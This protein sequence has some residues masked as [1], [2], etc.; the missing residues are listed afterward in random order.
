MIPSPV[1]PPTSPAVD[2]NPSPSTAD[3]APASA[4]A[5][6]PGADPLSLAGLAACVAEARAAALSPQSSPP[7]PTFFSSLR[8]RIEKASRELPE[9]YRAAVADPLRRALDG[10]GPGG[11]ARILAVDPGR[12]GP[13]RL[14]LDL[15]QAVLQRGEGYQARATAAFQEVVS[16]L[17]EGFLSAEDRRGV[18][19]PDHGVTPPLVR[20]G[21]AETGPYTW[22]ARVTATF[23]VGAAVVSLPA[24]NA[25]GG[26]LAWPALAHEAAGHDILEA[27]DGLREELARAVR[28]EVRAA[29]I[30]PAV[31]GYWAERID[32]AA[33]DVL[34]VLNMGP[35]AAVGLV[36]YFRAL[37][38]VWRGTSS[39]RSAGAAEDPHPAD[40]AR[41]YL[42]AETV[43]LLSF[44]GAGAWADRLLAEADRDRDR[45]R[46]G[47]VPVT[48][49]AAR[50]SAAAVARAIVRTR[51]RSLEG[52]SLGEIQDWSDRDEA[53]VAALRPALREEGGQ[54]RAGRYVKGAYAA[55]AVAAAVYEAVAGGANPARV[56]ER[57]VSVL[58]GMHLRNPSWAG[59]PAAPPPARRE[60]GAA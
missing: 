13:A 47:D 57:M 4:V 11:F 36:G 53:V 49:E 52:R 10:M 59:H 19:P 51:V 6:R 2:W 28:R 22:P 20:W 18:K 16:D 54:P 44:Q 23:D 48:P 58:E 60:S 30:D 5:L 35:A 21:P 9:A 43:R 46:F 17:Y 40:L 45:I 33:A 27:D 39:L 25:T 34:G 26:L 12:T 8:A 50:A 7:D 31:G 32:E 3:P 55:H 37:N 14:L 29:R 41:A 38:G 56:Q 24:A 1:P 42:A 15:C